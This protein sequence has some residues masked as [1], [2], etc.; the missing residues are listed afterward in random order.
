[1]PGLKSPMSTSGASSVHVQVWCEPDRAGRSLMV[2]DAS[3]IDA[4]AACL[5]GVGIVNNGPQKATTSRVVALTDPDGNR[6][7]LTG[8]LT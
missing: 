2:L 6:L 8:S 4:I 5:N 1:M 3:D 7:V